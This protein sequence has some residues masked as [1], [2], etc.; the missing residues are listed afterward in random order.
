[1]EVKEFKIRRE[2]YNPRP[3]SKD[4][5]S[6]K[7]EILSIGGTIFIFSVNGCSSIEELENYLLNEY[8]FSDAYITK[9]LNVMGSTVIEDITAQLKNVWG[10][11]EKIN[12]KEI[13]RFVG[14]SFNEIELEH[15]T[16][17]FIAGVKN[18]KTYIENVFSKPS[19]E[20]ARSVD[21]TL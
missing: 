15:K 8:G 16:N 3:S 6:A 9:A 20:W 1:M 14:Y 12:G 7:D 18:L 17:L 13:T 21:W 10:M 5:R 11:Q 4:S 19:F 2:S